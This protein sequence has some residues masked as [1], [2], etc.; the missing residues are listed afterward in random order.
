[1]ESIFL[2]GCLKFSFAIIERYRKSSWRT[3][4]IEHNRGWRKACFMSWNARVVHLQCKEVENVALALNLGGVISTSGW[5]FVGWSN[6]RLEISCRICI[7]VASSLSR[8][9]WSNC[10]YE[11]STWST[12]DL[13]S[14]QKLWAPLLHNFNLEHHFV[15][16]STVASCLQFRLHFA[17]VSAHVSIWG[18]CIAFS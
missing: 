12:D 3:R 14:I 15:T 18:K 7:W 13:P 10:L 5:G 8:F 2:N 11:I 9:S 16:I 17:C 4:R 1:M 6:L